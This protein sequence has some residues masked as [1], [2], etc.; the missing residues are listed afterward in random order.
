MSTY[1]ASEAQ[2]KLLKSWKQLS[3][4]FPRGGG[5]RTAFRP[6][7]GGDLNKNFPKIQ[8]PGGLPE[9]DVEASIWLV[10]YL[11][12]LGAGSSPKEN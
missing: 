6:R 9:L 8:M 2:K 11:G 7:E 3:G 4:N 5:I 12:G 10:H 1:T